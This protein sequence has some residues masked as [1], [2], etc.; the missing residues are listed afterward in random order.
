MGKR[1]YSIL[2]QHSAAKC[3]T[4]LHLSTLF[5]LIFSK[6][7]FFSYY[8]PISFHSV[9]TRLAIDRFLTMNRFPG[10]WVVLDRL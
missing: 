6:S 7:F 4:F 2:A 3:W 5:T 9:V 8:F 10:S 1:R